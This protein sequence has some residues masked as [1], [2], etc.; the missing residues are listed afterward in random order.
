M[1]A[2]SRPTPRP[3]PET[4]HFWEACQEGRFLLPKCADCGSHWFP[5][6]GFCPECWSRNWEW[7]HA[8]GL[9]LLHTFVIF[10]RQYHPAFEPPYAVGVV[11]LK[12][13]PRMLSRIVTEDIDKLRVGMALKL[14]WDRSGDWMI[15]AFQVL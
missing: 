2:V 6:S 11:H 9:G 12:E 14:T 3:S 10:R 15:P 1:T 4:S 7:E 8:S 5:P 13:G